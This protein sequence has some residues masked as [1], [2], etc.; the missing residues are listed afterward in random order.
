MTKPSA[1]LASRVLC[2]LPKCIHNSR[3]KVD[4]LRTISFATLP[5]PLYSIFIRKNTCKLIKYKILLNCSERFYWLN[6]STRFNRRT[7]ASIVIWMH[8]RAVQKA[9]EKLPA[10][11]FRVVQ[12]WNDLPDHL[13]SISTLDDF[14][15]ELYFYLRSPK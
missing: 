8:D 2:Q 14:K 1:S 5:L 7:G 15:R 12:K 11:F 9:C 6:V 13:R 4:K 10:L 3:D